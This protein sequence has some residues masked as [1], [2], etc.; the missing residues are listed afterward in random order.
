M[1]DAN[2]KSDEDELERLE[3]RLQQLHDESARLNA[4]LEKLQEESN[5]LEAKRLA[6]LESRRLLDTETDTPAT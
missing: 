3:R 1:S 4:E 2:S 6:T 5:R